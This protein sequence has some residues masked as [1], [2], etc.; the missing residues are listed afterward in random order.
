MF[1]NYRGK[2]DPNTFTFVN[3][4]NMT[5]LIFNLIPTTPLD[6]NKIVKNLSELFIPFKYTFTFSLIISITSLI[7]IIIHDYH[8]LLSNPFVFAFIMFM[9]LEE[10]NGEKYIYNRFLVERLTHDFP[11]KIKNIKNHYHMYK[12]RVHIINKRPEKDYLKHVFT[13]K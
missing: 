5:I 8:I 11:Y 12:N 7:F 10:K 13:P 6:G 2:I 3:T 4:Y 9:I 1:L